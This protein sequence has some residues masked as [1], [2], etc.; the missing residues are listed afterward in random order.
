VVLITLGCTARFRLIVRKPCEV[1]AT[2]TT[3]AIATW[4]FGDWEKVEPQQQRCNAS[5]FNKYYHHFDYQVVLLVESLASIR[6]LAT[7][8]SCRP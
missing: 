4:P 8:Q 3:V 1:I 5:S 7:A 6:L 2:S